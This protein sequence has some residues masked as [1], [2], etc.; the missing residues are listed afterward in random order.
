MTFEQAI[1]KNL[2]LIPLAA[3]S[4]ALVWILTFIVWGLYV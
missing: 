2:K 4:V 1:I 3:A